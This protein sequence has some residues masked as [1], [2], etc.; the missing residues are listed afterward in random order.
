MRN[1]LLTTAAT[2]LVPGAA[3]LL[4][5]YWILQATGGVTTPTVGLLEVVSILLALV[6]AGMVVWVSIVFVTH[7][8]GTPVP[9]EPPRNFVAAGLYR[10]VRNPMYFGALL[11]LFAEAIFFR[12]VWIL[13]YG[14]MLWLALH[15]F[16]VFLE[17]P[18]LEGR[19]GDTY[20][21]YRQRTPRWIP[22]R[23]KP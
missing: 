14:G 23:P 9:I 22:R 8:R 17:E 16:T 15:T 3:V 10:F 7:G 18:Q 6:G 20:R 11:A 13:L 19:F 21:E 5:P 4:G 12:S 1:I 2:I